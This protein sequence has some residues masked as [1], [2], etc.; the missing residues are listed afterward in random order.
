MERNKVTSGREMEECII[1]EF[2]C[3]APL[4]IPLTTRARLLFSNQP[5]F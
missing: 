2:A 4:E 1:V 3:P 5:Q